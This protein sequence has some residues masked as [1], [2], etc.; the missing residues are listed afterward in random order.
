MQIIIPP[1]HLLKVVKAEVLNLQKVHLRRSC[2]TNHTK[3][4]RAPHPLYKSQSYLCSNHVNVFRACVPNKSC[5][6]VTN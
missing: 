1:G 2:L 6:P 4:H 3:P 5:P